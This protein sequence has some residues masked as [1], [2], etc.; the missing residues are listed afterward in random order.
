MTAP[1]D[2]R[3]HAVALAAALREARTTGEDR[4][5]VCA[6]VRRELGLPPGPQ[7]SGATTWAGQQL[8]LGDS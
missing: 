7:S 2:R 3:E 4:A 1:V 6:R 5:A 8:A